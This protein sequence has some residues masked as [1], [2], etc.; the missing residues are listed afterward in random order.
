MHRR[1]AIPPEQ[2]P[3]LHGGAQPA[4]IYI[5]IARDFELLHTWD[6][7]KK[8]QARAA[9]PCHSYLPPALRVVCSCP[10]R[11]VCRLGART[12]GPGHMRGG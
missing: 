7:G 10:L 2:E 12:G 11:V 8:T 3:V 1:R 4:T 9:M 5:C 6:G